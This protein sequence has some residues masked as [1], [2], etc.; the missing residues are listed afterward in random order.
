ML[1]FKRQM[2]SRFRGNDNQKIHARL[3]HPLLQRNS[4]LLESRV[5]DH[6]RAAGH[7]FALP[8]DLLPCLVAARRSLSRHQ[9]HHVPGAGL[10]DD[11]DVAKRFRQQLIE[12][13]P[14]QGHGQHHFRVA[15][16]LVALRILRRLPRRRRR[17]RPDGGRRRLH[18]RM[19][20]YTRAG[21]FAVLDFD[22][23]FARLR[24]GGGARH[25]RRHLGG[26]VRPDGVVPK[27]RDLAADFLE[28]RVNSIHSL[29][30]FWQKLSHLNPFFYTIDGFR[31]G[32]FGQADISPWIS[33]AVVGTTFLALS[34][35]TFL[36]I[37]SGYKLRH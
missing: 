18:R 19:V 9:L 36:M 12:P 5:P 25:S 11:V 32:F 20:F 13:D 21:A 34:F 22:V 23:R 35:F 4:A 10:G 7:D 6:R 30:E 1:T 31:Y 24:H 26:Q 37:R 27:F 29:P 16:T 2:D 28:R 3:L 33:L 8:A 17:A 15:G 14:I